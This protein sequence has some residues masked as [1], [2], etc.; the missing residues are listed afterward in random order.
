MYRLIVSIAFFIAASQSL[1]CQEIAIRYFNKSI[2]YPD[3]TAENPVFVHVSVKNTGIEPLRFKLADERVFN[4]D[5]R[6]R[7]MQSLELEATETLLR[8]RTTS[9]TV[10]FREIILE[11]GEEY[12]FV[13]NVKD[14]IAIPSPGMYYLDVNFYPEL[15]KTANIS[16]VSNRLTLDVRPSPSASS[17][18]ILPVEAAAMTILTP[19]TISPDRV[20][21]QTIIARQR[22]QWDKYFLYM[23]V[24]QMLLR[25]G[26][27]ERKYRTASAF[28]RENMINTFKADLM[29]KRIEQDI[30]AVPEKFEIERTNYS[31]SRGTVSVIEWFKYNTFSEKKRYTYSVRAVDGIW[32]IYD[33]TVESGDRIG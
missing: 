22:G 21:E 1:F 15:Y 27:R 18:K 14:Y 29:Q 7:N 11:T 17:S 5:F 28:E 6:V 10:Y 12:S 26:A 33:Y 19:E 23:N 13:E 25:D 16:I 30:V 24:E 4:M 31:Q 32:Q 3:H 9:Q 20:V 2:Y 8:K